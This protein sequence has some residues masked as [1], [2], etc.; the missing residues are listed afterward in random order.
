MRQKLSRILRETGL[1][2]WSIE[3][4]IHPGIP[5]LT[6][7]GGAWAELKWL[8]CWPKR[9]ETPVVI[10]HFTPVQRVTILGRA[11]VDP[12]GMWLILQVGREWLLFRGQDVREIGKTL[13]QSELRLLAVCVTKNPH[14]LLPYLDKHRPLENPYVYG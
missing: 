4:P 14:D 3:C 11:A 1:D 12:R 13:P 5:D 8:A 6:W 7:A 9:A 10:P 2:P